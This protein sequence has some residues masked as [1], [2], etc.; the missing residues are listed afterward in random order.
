MPQPLTDRKQYCNTEV[1]EVNDEGDDVHGGA[2]GQALPNR[3]P[4][5]PYNRFDGGA[6]GDQ[7]CMVHE[8]KRAVVYDGW[9]GAMCTGDRGYATGEVG[10]SDV[11]AANVSS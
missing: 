2:I 7:G 4:Q 10:E 9:D 8:G 11:A 5:R 1:D 3:H 6:P